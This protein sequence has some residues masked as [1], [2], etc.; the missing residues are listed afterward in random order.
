M[1][2]D[3]KINKSTKSIMIDK[4]NVEDNL[5][6]L[7]QNILNTL[8][9][10]EIKILEGELL[11]WK[12]SGSNAYFNCK[13]NLSY[14]LSCT[15]WRI[16][17]SPLFNTY[18]NFKDGDK[19]KLYGNFSILKK[20]FS[21]YFNVKSI[22]KIGLGDYLA[23]HEQY[24]NKIYE[25]GWNLNK[26][27]IKKFPY[28]IGI[29]TS[30]EGA[31]IQDILQT[32]K[33]DKFIGNIFL[34]NTIVQGKSCPQSIINRLTFI[35]SNYQNLDLVLITRGGGSYEDLVGF[36][37]W[38]VLTCIHNCNLITISAVGH[39]IDNQLSDEVSDYKFA[40]PSIAAKFIT[41]SQNKYL[42]LLSKSKSLIEQSKINISKSKK[43]FTNITKN[44]N[45]IINNYDIIESK[46]KLF[47]YSNFI[48][49]KINK[50][51]N[52]KKIFYNDLNEIKPTIFKNN[53]EIYSVDEVINSNPKKL[54]IVLS[55]GSVK[56][57]YRI[58]DFVKNN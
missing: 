36:S 27:I 26:S 19:V 11:S 41:E 43:I 21:I 55:D 1:S 30:S 39:Q 45:Q 37:N 24:R 14:Q 49:N 54:N 7:Y 31:A 20:S 12:I 42:N 48:K 57:Y 22:E 5:E 25:L 9:T 44:Y 28:N 8:G 35:E 18:K 47:K 6:I 10:N 40:T 46:E 50:Y 29:I 4:M 51:H 34:F 53:S 58:I 15:F 2:S 13:I 33:L 16:T 23:L 17:D 32:F 56:I 52:A 38:E 3:I